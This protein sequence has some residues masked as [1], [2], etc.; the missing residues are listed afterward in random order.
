[1]SDKSKC[2]AHY[3]GDGIITCDRAIESMVHGIEFEGSA[4]NVLCHKWQTAAEYLWRWPRKGG[5]DD[6]KK[7]RHI[8]DQMISRLEA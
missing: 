1:M 5:V 6:L 3:A 2:P 7:A 8:I 4:G